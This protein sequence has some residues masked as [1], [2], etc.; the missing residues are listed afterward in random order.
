M[1]NEKNLK[2]KPQPARKA[3]AKQRHQRH[4]KAP[5]AR[6][7]GVRGEIP[8][9][10]QEPLKPELRAQAP[11]VPR[12][13][14]ELFEPQ[15]WDALLAGLDHDHASRAPSAAHPAADDLW[16]RLS[17]ARWLPKASGLAQPESR[18]AQRPSA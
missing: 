14:E 6:N 16:E 13:A 12:A 9:V 18:A 11:P 3:G 4:G 15:E 1:E 5:H 8:P 17:K 7:A 10:G 2:P